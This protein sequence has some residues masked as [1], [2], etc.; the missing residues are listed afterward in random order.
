MATHSSENP[1]DCG[2]A[3]SRTRLKRL[4]SSSSSS[5]KHTS[6]EEAVS[7]SQQKK[8]NAHSALLQQ[9]P[10]L[11][12]ESVGGPV[13]TSVT[14]ASTRLLLLRSVSASPSHVA[15]WKVSPRICPM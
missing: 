9:H 8:S 12:G 10:G 7:H 11:P 13:R 2:V 5:G 3:Q 1:R 4:S 6:Q 15:T 14:A